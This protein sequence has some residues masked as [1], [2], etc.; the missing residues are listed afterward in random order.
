[1]DLEETDS[2]KKWE[3]NLSEMSDLEVRNFFEN[4]TALILN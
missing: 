1:M 4:S 2:E 3:H